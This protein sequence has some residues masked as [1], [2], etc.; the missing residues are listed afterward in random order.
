M[1]LKVRLKS[2]ASLEK[3]QKNIERIPR[4][5]HRKFVEETPRDRGNAKRKTGFINGNT[6]DANYNYAVRLN[7]GYSKQAK[8]GMT[9]PTINYIRKLLRAAKYGI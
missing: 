3:V 8:L 1:R 4:Q 5:A 6:I 2:P 9:V 7:E